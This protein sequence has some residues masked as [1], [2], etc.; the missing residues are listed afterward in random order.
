MN[1]LLVKM[2]MLLAP[3]YRKFDVN[4]AQLSVILLTKLK[5]DDRRP[6]I[7]NQR[8]KKANNSSNWLALFFILIM[9][10]FMVIFLVLFKMPLIGHTIYFSVF[11]VFISI[12]IISDFT[13]VLI[14]DRDTYI[15]LPKPVSDRTVTISRILHI[16]LHISKI[17]FAFTLPG[18]IYLFVFDSILSGMVFLLE[19]LLASLLTI[20]L[21]NMVYLLVMKFTT[22]QK[23]KDTIAYIQIAFSVIIF[24]AYYLL[25]RI[26]DIADLKNIDLVSNNFI[27]FLPTVWIAAL[28]ELLVKGSFTLLNGVMVIFAV[29]V[30]ALAMFIV[31]KYLAPGFNKKIAMMGGSGQQEKQQQLTTQT[32]KSSIAERLS[33]IV[34]KNKIEQAGF[35]ITWLLTNRFRDFKVKAYP[36]FAYVPVYFLYIV[37][38]GGRELSFT[39]K[40][41]DLQN[42]KSYIF[43]M[44]LTGFILTTVLQHVSQSDRYKAS[45]IYFTTPHKKP[46]LILSG[47]FLALVVKYFL[48][49]FI[50]ISVFCLS[51]WGPAIIND[52]LISFCVS[53]MYGILTS[54]F[55]IKGLPFSQPVNLKQSG[56]IFVGLLIF[57]VPSALG[58]MHYFIVKW[59]IIVW[60]LAAVLLLI[61]VIMLKYFRNESWENLALA[62]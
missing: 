15:I 30:P 26:I 60:V 19:C 21:I 5:I 8:N 2:V 32:I 58:F 24:A 1:K 18:M 6:N 27:H 11:M 33:K 17:I 9:G 31:V 48:P 42:G 39:Q 55:V 43:L 38:M 36:A 4:T 23:F 29:L 47:M 45:W 13:T 57:L 12:T 7:Y 3:L 28:H 52:L 22:L 20:F 16:T 62:D 34:S 56:K 54:L 41:D 25:P 51:V 50:I 35:K 61:N 49:F 10:I 37:L 53:M 59:E 44:Y 40:W 46:G 14:D